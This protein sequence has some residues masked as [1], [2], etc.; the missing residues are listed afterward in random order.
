MIVA[1]IPDVHGT[2]LWEQIIP[3]KKQYD[4]IIILGDLVDNWI[5]KWPDQL[6]NLYRIFKFKRDNPKKVDLLLGNHCTSYILAEHCSGFQPQHEFD[7]WETYNKNKSL[8]EIVA[9]YDN[10]IFSHAGVSKIWMNLCG[11]KEPTEINQLFKERP[12][13]FRWVGPNGYGRNNSEGPLWIRENLIQCNIEN[14]N[15]VVGHTELRKD[16]WPTVLHGINFEEIIYI[17]TNDHDCFLELDTQT[18]SYKQIIF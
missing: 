15:Q 1:V 17:D 2:N 7:I 10:W 5:N 12:N 18:K 8:Y 14:Y 13:F 4:K 6:E 3:L 11:I 16:N 9:I